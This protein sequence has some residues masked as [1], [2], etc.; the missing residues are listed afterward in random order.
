MEGKKGTVR[1]KGKKRGGGKR[2]GR[3]EPRATCEPGSESSTRTGLKK[4][5]G[6]RRT[7]SG[8]GGKGGGQLRRDF[9]KCRK[10]RKAQGKNHES[11][12]P[13][14]CFVNAFQTRVKIP[15]EGGCSDQGENGLKKYGKRGGSS[16]Y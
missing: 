10:K 13:P 16:T 14:S 11:T 9:R 1:G 15:K 4:T 3:L 8:N 5:K 7:D 12:G 6:K 2:G